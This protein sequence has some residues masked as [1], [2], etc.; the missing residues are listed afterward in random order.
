MLRPSTMIGA[1]MNE[2]R[3][4]TWHVFAVMPLVAHLKSPSQSS[5]VSQGQPSGAGVI[6]T[7]SPQPHGV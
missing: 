4:R 1:V 3:R 5:D 7:G 2:H 6:G